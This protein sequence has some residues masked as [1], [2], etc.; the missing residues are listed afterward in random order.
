MRRFV[1]YAQV[2]P[3]LDEGTGS[4]ETSSAALDEA[5]SSV[6]FA[7]FFALGLR[8]LGACPRLG[9]SGESRHSAAT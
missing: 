6:S 8:G 2:H 3:E 1:R 7:V 5:V 9:F 4:E